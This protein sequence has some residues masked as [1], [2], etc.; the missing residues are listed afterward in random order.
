LKRSNNITFTT[1][2]ITILLEKQLCR[3]FYQNNNNMWSTNYKYQV[4]KE[5][6][7][8]IIYMSSENS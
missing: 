6:T 4:C 7:L 3:A 8:P 1:I 5:M 2:I